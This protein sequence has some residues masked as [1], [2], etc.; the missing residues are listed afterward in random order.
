MAE[1]EELRNSHTKLEKTLKAEKSKAT[2][3]L[4]TINSLTKKI[5]EYEVV[6]KELKAL[7]DFWRQQFISREEEI[8]RRQTM[9]REACGKLRAKC[10]ALQKE[11]ASRDFTSE[12]LNS[13]EYRLLNAELGNTKRV[14]A[15]EKSTLHNL[16]QT[17]NRVYDSS[18]LE[19]SELVKCKS[20]LKEANKSEKS[21][22]TTVNDLKSQLS[23]LEV[24]MEKKEPLVKIGAAI[25]LRFLE[26][27]RE[28]IHQVAR[29]ELDLT[30]IAE[31]NAA[32]HKG[33][34]IAD[35]AL[36]EAGLIPDAYFVDC[37]SLFNDLYQKRPEHFGSVG[38]KVARILNCQATVNV[39]KAT[40]RTNDSVAQRDEHREKTD[41]L[42]LGYQG[43][44]TK[45]EFE[46]D[47]AVERHILRVEELADEIAKIDRGK[48]RRPRASQRPVRSS[49][50]IQ[51]LTILTLVVTRIRRGDSC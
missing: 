2:A 3:R 26:Y 9:E 42:L 43:I 11:L 18:K 30:L 12:I 23:S 1:L 14:L 7:S 49:S 34:G 32:A 15:N 29:N 40:N 33:N 28:L 46:T 51:D 24:D 20:R 31:G 39:S 36:F 22:R 21:L 41:L 13:Q 8:D 27:G 6:T 10:S 19:H 35:A 48:R 44:F 5:E 50:Y 38:S 47:D 17:Y 25:R 16:Q 37:E 4:D 45:E